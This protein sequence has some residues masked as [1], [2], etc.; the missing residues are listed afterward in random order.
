M[1]GNQC[2]KRSIVLLNK[3]KKQLIMICDF[4]IL[5]PDTTTTCTHAIKESG[6]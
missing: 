1:R 4:H 3:I 2:N 5:K 6:Q